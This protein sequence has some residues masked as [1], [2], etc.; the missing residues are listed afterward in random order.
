MKISLK[1][2]R[3]KCE[4]SKTVQE[5]QFEPIKITVSLEG[6]MPDTSN[7]QEELDAITEFLENAV[8]E[9]INSMIV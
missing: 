3:I 5:R 4:I 7:P 9:Q 6:T 8:L 1:D 2:R